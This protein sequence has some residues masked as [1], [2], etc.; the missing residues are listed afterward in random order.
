MK[1]EMLH[2]AIRAR[3]PD[4]LGHFYANLFDGD[5]FVHPVMTGLGIVIVKISHPDAI[6]RGLL[7]FWPWDVVWNGAQARFFKVKAA[8]STTSY[9]HLAVRVA[10]DQAGIAA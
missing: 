3:D 5:F 6:F 7:E 1:A 2:V 4:K 10:L 8:P 9:G